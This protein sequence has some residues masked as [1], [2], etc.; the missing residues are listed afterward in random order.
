MLIKTIDEIKQSVAVNAGLDI[1]TISAFIKAAERN[2][3]KPAIGRQL[4][5]LIDEAYN[6]NSLTS[7]EQD[8]LPLLQDVVSQFAIYLGLPQLEI[9]ISDGAVTRIEA[10]N[11]KTAY[12]Y[13][14][15]S[16]RDSLFDGAYESLEFLLDYL[17]GHQNAFPLW[18]TSDERAEMNSLLVRSGREMKQFCSSIRQPQR[19]YMAVAS[20]MHT[21]ED[22]TLDDL[23]GDT[24]TELKDKQ[25]A[26]TLTDIEKP[27][28]K[29]LKKGIVNLTMGKAM[30]QLE[31]RVDAT[32][33]VT[34][35]GN[36]V[37]ST[38]GEDSNRSTADPKRVNSLA[39][40]FNTVGTAY[41][42]VATKLLNKSASDT[43]FPTWYG[44]MQAAAAAIADC[45]KIKDIN[46]TLNGSFSL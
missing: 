18:E 10:D 38:R 28:V 17:E 20:M 45:S 46:Q 29:A 19:T 8:L 14:T 13:Q 22:L 23:I 7:D 6:T 15:L 25:T 42:D 43:V 27:V 35:V 24:F 40:Q 39:A 9:Q 36:R 12:K 3:L 32:D 11:T 1:N 44:T 16:L 21:I 2:Y 33:G 4:Y 31:M 34:I 26:G 41:L 37:D 5:Q 30:L